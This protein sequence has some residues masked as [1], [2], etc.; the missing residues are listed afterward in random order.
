MYM[1]P[2]SWFSGR[3]PS[4]G[5]LKRMSRQV[6][7]Q[8]LLGSILALAL[9][10]LYE[11]SVRYGVLDPSVLV[12]HRVFQ[13]TSLPVKKAR[14]TPASRAASTLARWAPDQYSSCPMDTNSLCSSSS[15]PRRSVSTSVV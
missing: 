5:G 10:S 2:I 4:Y 15:A 11:T 12:S 13:Y 8:V 3:P 6:P 9:V 1:L 14:L 7:V